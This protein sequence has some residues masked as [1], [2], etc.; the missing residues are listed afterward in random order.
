MAEADPRVT[1][2]FRWQADK[3]RE[4]GSPFTGALLDEAAASL[5]RGGAAADA[6]GGW[7][8]PPV[9]DALP[10][11]LAGALHA[12][13]LEGR[14]AALAAA[15]PH[16]DSAGDARAAWAAA[17]AYLRRCPEDVAERLRSPPQTNETGRALG[18]F[19]GL[20]R[21]AARFSEPIDLY[22]LGASAGLN[23]NMDSFGYRTAAWARE[24][25]VPIA[26]DW[27]GAAPALAAPLRV[28][29]RAGCDQNPL[30]PSRPEDRRR[31]RAYVWADQFERKAR[32]DAAL[33]LAQARG[34]QVDRAD[35]ADWIE[36]RL[37][38]RRPGVLSVVY[39]SVFWQYPPEAAR[40]RMEAAI[41]AAGAAAVARAP[42]AWLRFEPEDAPAAA[43]GGFRYLVDMTVWPG[44]ERE[45]LAE[46]DPH[47]RWVDWRAG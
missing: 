29:Q 6:V 4:M 13:V 14:D 42:L 39:H 38:A 12:V 28:E 33:A 27:R 47:G 11:R 17:E 30:D 15:Y 31:L 7:P 23:L 35:A 9:Q 1:A 32:L 25:S 20:L 34:T 10:L 37:A 16:P 22:E 21:L 36:A 3:C 43:G 40:Q 18:L 2:A 46:V 44:G 5:E 24:G 41:R 19:P 45:V 8:G 26:G